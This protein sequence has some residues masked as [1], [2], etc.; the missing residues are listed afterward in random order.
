MHI[1]LCALAM[2]ITPFP[3]PCSQ[4]KF[5]PS[6][7]SVRK[8]MQTLN[9]SPTTE[10]AFQKLKCA[11]TVAPVMAYPMFEAPSFWTLMQVIVQ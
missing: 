1:I 10:Q 4:L 5:G 7:S 2:G 11:L 6:T 9:W 8:D 3:N